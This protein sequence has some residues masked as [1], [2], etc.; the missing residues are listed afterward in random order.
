MAPNLEKI[1]IILL[2]ILILTLISSKSYSQSPILLQNPS[3]EDVPSDATVPHGWLPCAERTTPDILPGFW[4]V[5]LEPEQGETYIGLITRENS[6]SES[7]GQRLPEVLAQGQCYEM[8]LFLA[9]SN[10]YTGYSRPVHLR[11]WLS[12]SKCEKQHLIYDSGLVKNTEWELHKFEF[13]PNHPAQYIMI[14]AF[15]SDE[16][17]SHKG[18]ILIDQISPIFKCKRV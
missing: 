4:G 13:S 2:N 12:E 18:N 1:Y 9:K 8:S 6:T 3:F 16:N 5:Y 11:I 17:F 7:I 14:E 15:I 10:N